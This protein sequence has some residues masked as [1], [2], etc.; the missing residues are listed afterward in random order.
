VNKHVDIL[1]YHGKHGDQF[2]LVD[3]PARMNAAMR[4]LFKQLDDMRCYKS[5]NTRF[6]E[7]LALARNGGVCCIKAILES[8][9]GYE[10]ESWDIEAAE[11]AE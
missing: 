11:I 1:I 6:N 7:M 4:S 2:W 3:T 8:R 10:Y 9:C 5:E